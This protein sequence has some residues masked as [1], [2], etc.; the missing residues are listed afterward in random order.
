M[1]RPIPFDPDQF[2]KNLQLL[3]H[4]AREERMED[5]RGLV[6][7]IVPTC[8]PADRHGSEHKGKTYKEQMGQ[9]LQKREVQNGY[10]SESRKA[11][12]SLFPDQ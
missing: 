11:F 6:S 4:A 1:G 8:H 2:L 5:I 9:V 12:V 10:T 3:M 7:A